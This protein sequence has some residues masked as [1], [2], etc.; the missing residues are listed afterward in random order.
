MKDVKGNDKRSL[1]LVFSQNQ[2]LGLI[3]I[4]SYYLNSYVLR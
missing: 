3:Y 2:L 4:L 1:W